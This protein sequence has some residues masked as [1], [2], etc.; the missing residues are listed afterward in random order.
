MQV[1]KEPTRITDK[2]KTLVDLEFMN[3]KYCTGA[4]VLNYIVSDHMPAYIFL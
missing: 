4:G 2:S 3:I 1:I